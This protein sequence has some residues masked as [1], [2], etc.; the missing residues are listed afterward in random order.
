MMLMEAEKSYKLL[1][2]SWRTQEAGGVSQ[3]PEV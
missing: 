1:P 3:S 2:A